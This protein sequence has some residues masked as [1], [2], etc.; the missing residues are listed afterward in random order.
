M[1]VLEG[2][3][4]SVRRIMRS[5]LKDERHHDV[6]I[7]LE[8]PIDHREFETW[9][10]AFRKIDRR[11]PIPDGYSDFLTRTWRPVELCEAPAECHRLLL[12]FRQ[13]VR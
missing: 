5:I 12:Y 6:N 10:M 1:Q 9:R 13:T 11:F 2:E 4:A 7:V 8:E 3:E